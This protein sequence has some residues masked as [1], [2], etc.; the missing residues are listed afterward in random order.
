RHGGPRE[1]PDAG[2]TLIRVSG[3]L[4]KHP[5]NAYAA[6]HVRHEGASRS[7]SAHTGIHAAEH[8]SHGPCE[9]H[10][11]AEIAAESVNR[12]FTLASRASRYIASLA[13]KGFSSDPLSHDRLSDR[14]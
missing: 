14:S 10:V 2:R 4:R 7:R 9:C 6:P 8:H 11:Y 1:W 5:P 13:V 3:H 12:K